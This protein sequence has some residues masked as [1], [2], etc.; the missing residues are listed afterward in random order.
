MNQHV[1]L[2]LGLPDHPLWHEFKHLQIEVDLTIAYPSGAGGHWLAGQSD[3]YRSSAVDLN[4]YESQCI[5]LEPD[6]DLLVFKDGMLALDIDLDRLYAA[7]RDQALSDHTKSTVACI[8]LPPM[9]TH[10]I[11]DYHTDQLAVIECQADTAAFV[12]SLGRCKALLDTTYHEK[13]WLRRVL[14]PDEDLAAPSRGY[15]TMIEILQESSRINLWMTPLSWMWHGHA[16]LVGCDCDDVVE[17]QRYVSA[18]LFNSVRSDRLH[19]PHSM[20]LVQQDPY[21]QTAL[22]YM[23]AVTT[24]HVIDYGKYY[25]D[26][27]RSGCDRLDAISPRDRW[28]YSDANIDLLQRA[29]SIA[30]PEIR[31][32]VQQLCEV[33][34]DRIKISRGR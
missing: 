19:E 11:T 6:D 20:L 10:Q 31:H 26:G 12:H 13:Q 3:I 18:E 30:D 1:S 22:R 33:L 2:E 16:G 32:D 28:T 29:S 27:M 15:A 9:L 5:W 24:C 34:S 7:M 17:F 25:L 14:P 21:Y 8:H 23:Q 4:R